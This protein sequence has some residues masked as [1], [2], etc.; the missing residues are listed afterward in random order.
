[1]GDQS[2]HSVLLC[3]FLFL[4][5]FAAVLPAA[6]D[7]AAQEYD[8]ELILKSYLHTFPE[9]IT[10]VE[11]VSPPVSAGASGATSVSSDGEWIIR[12]GNEAYY[13]AGG[14]L[15]PLSL[16]DQ[17]DSWAPH[18]FSPYPAYAPS[19]AE[20]RREDIERIRRESSVEARLA[21]DNRYYG[22]FMALYGGATEKEAQSLLTRINFLGRQIRVNAGIAAAL[23][24][25]DKAINLLAAGDSSLKAFLDTLASV[26]CFAW[27]EI[28][29]K[30]QMSLHSW[31]IALDMLPKDQRSKAIYWL[32]EQNRN[33]NW[34]MVSPER[35]WQPHPAVISAFEN[36]GFVWGGKW[37][38]YDNMHFEYRPEL[39]EMNRMS[40]AQNSSPVKPGSAQDIPHLMPFR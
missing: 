14:R 30:R 7:E 40:A 24:R 22:F 33:D 5:T 10:G 35:R 34:M 17:K 21:Q 15:L 11:K 25:I 26:E 4:F 3:G 28:R 8:G 19:P 16:L 2:G 20:Y 23:E 32:W 9:K 36:E 29:S 12:L 37:E 18:D 13:W 39:H 1:M 31:G 6:A 27:R 38:L